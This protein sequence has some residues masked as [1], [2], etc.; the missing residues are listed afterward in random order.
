MFIIDLLKGQGIPIKSRPGGA[1]LL[2]VA[3]A[4]PIIVSMIML[5]DYVSTRIILQR[6]KQVL[7][8]VEDYISN[9]SDGT[10]FQESAKLQIENMYACLAEAGD[11]LKQ[12]VQWTPVLEVLAEN[13]PNNL[14]LSRLRVVTENVR[15]ERPKRDDPSTIIM[16]SIPKKILSIVFFG[17][18][19]EKNNKAALEFLQ[20]LNDSKVL[21]EKVEDIRF[22]SQTT[23]EDDETMYYELECIF[24]HK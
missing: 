11:L 5:G 14:V 20:R 1:A 4:V 18:M 22:V 3:I 7:I 13:I 23:G 21:E 15:E 19:G 12:R 17:K 8:K 9:L 2:A 6:E 24:K 10:K 16:V